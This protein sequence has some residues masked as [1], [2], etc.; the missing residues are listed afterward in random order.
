MK[1]MLIMRVTDDAAVADYE[2]TPFEEIINKMGAYNED[3]INAGVLL[4]GEGLSDAAE[5]FVVDFASDDPIVTDGPYGE[6]HELFNGFWIIEVASRDEAVHWARRCPLGKGAKLEVRRFTDE[7]DFAE[8][9]DNEY[10][11]KEAGWRAEAGQ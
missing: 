5:G 6:I 8:Y 10:I 2:Q 9:A 7:S 3:M 11:Q 4:A 1:Y